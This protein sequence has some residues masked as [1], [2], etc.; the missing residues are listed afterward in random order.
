MIFRFGQTLTKLIE[1]HNR[2]VSA[3]I[4]WVNS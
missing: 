2:T 1:V 4:P 3:G